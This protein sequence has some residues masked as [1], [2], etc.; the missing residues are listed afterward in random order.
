MASKYPGTTALNKSKTAWS[1]RI[2]M[3]LPNGEKIDTT[4]RRNADGLRFKTAEEAYRAK[5]EHERQLKQGK[6]EANRN[7]K[8]TLANVYEHYMSSAE[9]KGK[10]AS[11]IAKQDSMWRQHISDRFGQCNVDEITL[12]DL[13]N[14]LEELYQSG[15]AYKYVEG[16]L[17]FF[18]LL[19]GYAYRLDLVNY[20]RY[21]KMFVDKGS[22]LSMPEMTQADFEE[23]E[24]PIETYSESQQVD[25]M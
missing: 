17:K 11:T 24:G 1:Y 19:F 23:A 5:L 4:C 2:K 8:T 14:Y 16:F 15:Y 6:I 7:N 10:A 3:T 22:R 12:T 9:A 18:Y 25:I 20:E 13:Q 21:L